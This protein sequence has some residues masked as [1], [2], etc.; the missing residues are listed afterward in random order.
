M[1]PAYQ[2]LEKLQE[3]VKKERIKEK[4]NRETWN[5]EIS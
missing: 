5:E 4:K 3:K 1:H 2:V